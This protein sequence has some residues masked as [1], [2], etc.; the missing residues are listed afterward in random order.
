MDGLTAGQGRTSTEKLFDASKNETPEAQSERIR[1]A[2]LSSAPD[3]TPTGNV[4]GVKHK[5]SKLT[6]KQRLFAS[7][8]VEGHSQSDAY[9]KAYDVRTD[10]AAV[11]AN[12][13]YK[14]SQNP[15]VQRLLEHSISK[16]TD[17]VLNDE[18][19]TRRLVMTS[20]LD[21]A[22]NMKGESSKLTALKLIGQA[23]GMFTDRVETTVTNINPEQLKQELS[24]HLALLDA[25]FKQSSS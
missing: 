16:R 22:Q 4:I 24:V 8:I 17:S 21:H 6:A 12:S 25:S 20:L 23:V 19:A 13:A 14:L 5:E 18:A 15:K 7:L 3:R 9:R 11:I 1:A 10:N 2:V